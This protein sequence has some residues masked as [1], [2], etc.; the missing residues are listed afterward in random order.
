MSSADARD[1]LSINAPAM[2]IAVGPVNP[3]APGSLL[4]LPR[5]IHDLAPALGL[6]VEPG[7]E[8]GGIALN[9]NCA[10]FGEPLPDRG[11]GK[12]VIDFPD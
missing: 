2:T 1:M 10:E 5:Q 7:A 8:L 12:G 3:L 4:L 9:G 11:V 6:G